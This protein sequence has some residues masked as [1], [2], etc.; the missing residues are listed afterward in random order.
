MG[1]IC[2][3]ELPRLRDA[4]EK[5][6]SVS[7]CSIRRRHPLWRNIP[8]TV[9]ARCGR[10]TILSDSI[11]TILYEAC[12]AGVDAPRAAQ[13]VTCCIEKAALLPAH[14]C[15]GRIHSFTNIPRQKS[16]FTLALHCEPTPPLL[17]SP[18]PRSAG[19]RRPT[20]W[21][22]PPALCLLTELAKWPPQTEEGSDRSSDL[23]LDRWL[24]WPK[25]A[26]LVIPV[27]VVLASAPRGRT[28]SE[29]SCLRGITNYKIYCLILWKME[30]RNDGLM[31]NLVV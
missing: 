23:H 27:D 28:G 12:V 16:H 4:D 30:R 8:G 9:C 17:S 14:V 20:E 15:W 25:L 6:N 19:G 24:H 18:E 29:T 21:P 13:F 26:R 1:P 5:G 11:I 31:S 22:H 2:L 10:L 7:A 3:H